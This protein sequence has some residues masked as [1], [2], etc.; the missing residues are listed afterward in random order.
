MLEYQIDTFGG[1]FLK[2]VT[3][4]VKN[5]FEIPRLSPGGPQ[6]SPKI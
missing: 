1:E 6:S 4:G 3:C 5:H 2:L